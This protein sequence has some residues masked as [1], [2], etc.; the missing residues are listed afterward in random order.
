MSPTDQPTNSAALLTATPGRWKLDAAGTTLQLQTKAMW[1]LAKVKA[2][3]KATDGS[4]TV[5][6]DGSV[7]GTLA[8][9]A[10]SVD[11]GN[12]R[13]DAH[14]RTAD[15]LE[16]DRYPTITYDINAVT[17]ADGNTV[18][19][20]GALAVH[21]VARPLDVIATVTD[22][23]AISASLTAEVDI[24]RSEWGLT[25]A[26]MGTRLD[27]HLVINARFLRA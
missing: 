19:V 26:K 14:L 21:G 6:D 24:N 20:S 27:N 10:A 23:D 16:V 12:K 25:W 17:P 11:S 3:F 8:I 5:A 4:A 15:F 7:A 13:R 1:G 18:K 22:A 9:D 2:T